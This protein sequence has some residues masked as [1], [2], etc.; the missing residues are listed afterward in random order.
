MEQY[1]KKFRDNIIGIEQV[2]ESPFGLKKIVY[3]DWTASGRMY[4]PIEEIFN[5]KIFGFVANTHTEATVTGKTMTIAYHTA[6]K[7]IK[8][9][10]NAGKEDVIITTGSGMT[11]AINKF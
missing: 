9:H 1:F 10:V 5:R 3:A 6:Q 7:I 4:K 11:G 2:F 8:V